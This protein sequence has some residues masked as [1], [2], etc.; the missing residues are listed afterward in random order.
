MAQA[1]RSESESG[2][3]NVGRLIHMLR[4]E[5]DWSLR[6]LEDESGIDAASLGRYEKGIT[7]PTIDRLDAIA[8]AFGMRLGDLLE[9]AERYSP[10]GLFL[11][12]LAALVA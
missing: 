4:W 5:R 1:A 11:D 9:R 12:D 6:D 10:T 8:G 3:T 7:H 2:R